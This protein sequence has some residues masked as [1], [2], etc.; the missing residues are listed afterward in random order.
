M[1]EKDKARTI[2]RY[3]RRFEEHGVDPRS[4]GWAKGRQE[5]R[6]EVA[7]RGLDL[8]F[9]SVLDVGCGF[10]DLYAHLKGRGWSGRYLGLD[11]VPEFLEVARQRH[12]HDGAEFLEHDL[13]ATSAAGSAAAFG[14]RAE[15]G[16]A[17]GLFNHQL[18]GDVATFV[19][20]MLSGLWSHTTK[21][22]VADFLS[23]T[24]DDRRDELHY[25]DPG[26]TLALGLRYT[27]RAVLDHSYM[28]FE[29]TLRLWH[30]DS[31][32]RDHPVFAGPA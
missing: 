28:P 6:F 4:L 32:P 11:V 14:H 15:L 18:D 19:E 8:A 1:D 13:S 17:I 26:Q 20:S 7:L 3:R 5:L 21:I 25:S 24:A 29:F 30:D 22:V 27:K 31:F 12:A 2:A 9:E 16:V 23:T 10:G